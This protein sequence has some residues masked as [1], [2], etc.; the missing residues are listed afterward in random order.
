MPPAR[1][2]D[3]AAPRTVSPTGVGYDGPGRAGTPGRRPATR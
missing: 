1:K 2:P 3:Q